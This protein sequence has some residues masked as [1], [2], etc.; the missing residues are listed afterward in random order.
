MTAQIS[1]RFNKAIP[2]IFEHEGGY[3]NH[4]QD[5]GGATNWGISLR[6]LKQIHYDING[7]GNVDV[8]D[9][10]ALSK[11]NATQIYFDNFWK[12]LYD[13]LPYENLA[14]KLFDFSVNAGTQEAN[15]VLQKSLN[16]LG[17]NLIVDGAIGQNTLNEIIKYSEEKILNI[18]CLEQRAF[19]DRIIDKNPQYKTFRQ[20]WYNRASFI[21]HQ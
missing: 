9:I 5:S 10:K 15:I 19:Y 17:S 1:N 6:L 4:I 8:L 18:Y 11:E 3:N 2:Y 21:P 20:G 12:N 14:I 7:D 13:R 16:D